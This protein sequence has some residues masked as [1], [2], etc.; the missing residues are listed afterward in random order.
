MK[1]SRLFLLVL[2]SA[3]SASLWAEEVVFYW[4][5][6]TERERTEILSEA[7]AG[8][9]FE[10]YRHGILHRPSYQK[11]LGEDAATKEALKAYPKDEKVAEFWLKKAAEQ[12]QEDA[13]W[14][15]AQMYYFGAGPVKEN[16]VD[17]AKW[18]R[19]SAEVGNQPAQLQL[20]FM[21]FKGQGVSK[22]FV[23]SYAWFNLAATGIEKA[24]KYR[25]ELEKIMT[26]SQLEKAQ[27]LSA[28]LEKR[29]EKEQEPERALRRRGF[30]GPDG[31]EK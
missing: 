2:A 14:E 20:G 11:E 29:I 9:P 21:L 5:P 12:G 25:Q 26:P 23:E 18:C 4:P 1:L 24:A 13:W 6:R 31:A 22:N 7:K 15:L 28:E 17:A 19:K 16:L 27:D 30:E 3:G 8:V 10:Q